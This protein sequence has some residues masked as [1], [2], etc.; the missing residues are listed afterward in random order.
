MNY[1]LPISIAGAIEI[2]LYIYIHILYSLKKNRITFTIR[3]IERVL[4][5]LFLIFFLASKY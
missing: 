3:F 1:S 5:Y 4:Y 2:L